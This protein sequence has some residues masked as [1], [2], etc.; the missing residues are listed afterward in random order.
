MTRYSYDRRVAF[1]VEPD[2]VALGQEAY[3]SAKTAEGLLFKARNNLEGV[4]TKLKFELYKAKRHGGDVR[5]I[6]SVIDDVERDITDFGKDCETF[7][8]LGLSTT[9][10]AVMS[11]L[12][13]EMPDTPPLRVVK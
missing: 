6:A 9:A 11:G 5:N 8:R 1:K 4:L 7:K 13:L 10:G 2:I 3:E 12:T